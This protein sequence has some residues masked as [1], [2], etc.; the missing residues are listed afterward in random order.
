MTRYEKG[1]IEKCAEYGVDGRALLK[2][3]SEDS[4]L[5]NT[6]NATAIGA[7]GG[8]GTMAAYKAPELVKSL[9]GVKELGFFPKELSKAILSNYGKTVG[10]AGL[11]AGG[12][13]GA[14]K[15]L[16]ALNKK[17]K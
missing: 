7:L 1:F 9:R 4:I 16:L 14:G 8:A 15:L 5:K 6:V 2:Q 12:A 17:D 10:K 3:A 11:L 13:I